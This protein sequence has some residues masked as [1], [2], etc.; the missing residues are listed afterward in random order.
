M[1]YLLKTIIYIILTIVFIFAFAPKKEIIL[2]GEQ[3]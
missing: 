2:F 1:K 3:I